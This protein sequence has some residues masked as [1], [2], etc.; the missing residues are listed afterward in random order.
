[1]HTHLPA[2]KAKIAAALAVRP[3]VFITHPA[4]LRVLRSMTEEQLHR[5][6][7]DHGW[8]TVRRVGGRQIEFYN[9]AGVR[10]E[11]S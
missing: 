10:R 9:D 11:V 7:A 8:R 3:E 4:E 2:L 6:A 5:F 1:M